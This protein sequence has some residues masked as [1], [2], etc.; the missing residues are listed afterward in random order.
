M[1]FEH[2]PESKYARR[3]TPAIRVSHRGTHKTV[4]FNSA[5]VAES[6]H[7]R[8]DFLIDTE[9]NNILIKFHER[10]R[11]KVPI[12]ASSTGIASK[13]VQLLGIPSGQYDA[14]WSEG[15]KGFTVSW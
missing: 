6:K 8:Y 5:L 1:N 14:I 12:R 7:V 15:H 10:G 13:T 4:Y 11:Y 2:V 3:E 9:G